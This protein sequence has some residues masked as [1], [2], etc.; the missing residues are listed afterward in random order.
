MKIFGMDGIEILKWMKVIDENICVI[1]M[2]VYGEFD[3]IQELK[4]LGVLMYFVKLFD[5]DEIRDVVKK[6]LFLKFNW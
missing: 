5:I 6:Y 4:E 3:M 1:I 2:M